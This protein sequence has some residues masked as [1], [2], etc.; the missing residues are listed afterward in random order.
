MEI[1]RQGKKI[2]SGLGFSDKKF[3]NPMNFFSGGWRMRVALAR[4]LLREPNIL[5]LDE[6]TNHLD[7]EA[8]IWLESFLTGWKGSILTISHDREFLDRSVN[9]IIEINF[10]KIILYQGN[11]SKFKNQKNLRLEQQISAYKNQQKEIKETQKFIERFRY[12]NTKAKQ[13]QSRG[14]MLV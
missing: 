6:P 3:N 11:Y 1:G 8:I 14:K 9:H 12:K 5:L 2:L 4:I 10:R 13:V 7:L